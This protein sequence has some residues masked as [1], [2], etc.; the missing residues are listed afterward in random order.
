MDPSDFE[1]ELSEG[2]YLAKLLK[3][4][5]PFS[6][7]FPRGP[8]KVLDFL[9]LGGEVEATNR[10]LIRDL[11]ITH[12]INCASGYITTGEVFYGNGIKYMGF[13]AEDE[14]GYDIMKHYDDVYNFIE[15]ARLSGGKAFIH[16]I[17]GVNRSGA[18]T[19]AYVMQHNK[20]GPVTAGILV[21]KAR[22][23]ILSNYDFQQQVITFARKRGY[24]SLDKHLVPSM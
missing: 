18:L 7:R 15:D 3:E 2:P 24:L 1:Q 9:Y 17:M 14:P 6:M 16:C 13:D 23:L 8:S 19:V 12:V 4:C 11:G 5:L 20:I 22:G 21:R 10:K